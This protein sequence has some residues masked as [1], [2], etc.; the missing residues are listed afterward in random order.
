MPKPVPVGH[1]DKRTEVKHKYLNAT[2]GREIGAAQKVRL[3]GVIYRRHILVDL[4]AGDGVPYVGEGDWHR[5]TSPGIFA[6]H[7]RY[8]RAQVPVWALLCERAPATFADL[9][10]RLAAHLPDLG[11]KPD[12]EQRWIAEEGRVL[13][14]AR[15]LDSRAMLCPWG[16]GDFVFLNN[17]PNKVH[18]WALPDNL[19]V[20]ASRGAVIR[21]FNTMGCNP[22]GLKR[23]PFKG[24]REVWYGYVDRVVRTLRPHQD[25]TLLAID[26]DDAQW[27]YLVNEPTV[28]VTEDVERAREMFDQR[29][30]TV[31]AVSL[32]A[33]RDRFRDLIHHL[34]LTAKERGETD[35]RLW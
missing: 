21:S 27:A 30:M 16:R 29:G 6:H 11:Y 26:G 19:P 25:L 34:F 14:E 32:R 28:W 33:Q 35:G 17:D 13:L 5:S 20:A 24:G 31:S 3:P 7:A 2:L 1:S 4:T 22:G 23:L 15:R 8:P 12:G 10:E 18:D 9:L